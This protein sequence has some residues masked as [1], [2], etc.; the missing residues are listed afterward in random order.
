LPQDAQLIFSV[1]AKSP[2]IFSREAN[3][4]VAS[5]D[6]ALSTTLS[7]ANR[8]LTLADSKVAVA[9]FDP[10]QAFG[11]SA[12]GPLKFRVVNQGVAGDWQPL[13]TL[14]R[15]PVLKDLECPPD[16][17][18]SC[19]L[20]GANLFLVDSIAGNPEFKEPVAVPVGFPGRAL[21]VPRP[22]KDGL[23]LKLRDDPSV[24]NVAALVAKEPPAPPPAE[25]APAPASS[26]AA[27]A[28]ENP[29]TAANS[30]SIS[31]P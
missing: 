11:F 10:T 3:I 2:A 27:A 18:Q 29:V 31:Y 13:V 28:G 6:E 23:Y 25:A 1:R 17:A 19:K 9:T 5:A 4:E 24:V 12:F 22:S 20:T 8:T 30:A 26:P 21:P 14:V 16:P 7:F 15:L